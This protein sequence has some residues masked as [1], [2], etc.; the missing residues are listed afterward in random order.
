MIQKRE[1]HGLILAL[2]TE[3]LRQWPSTTFGC[4]SSSVFLQLSPRLAPGWPGGTWSNHLICR[5]AWS[6]RAS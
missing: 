1:L 6:E 2:S 4:D 5:S 3:P